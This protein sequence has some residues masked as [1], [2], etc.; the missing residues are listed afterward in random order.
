MYSIGRGDEATGMA[1]KLVHAARAIYGHLSDRGRNRRPEQTKYY[2]AIG[3]LHVE[4]THFNR[5]LVY[6]A[7]FLVVF[8]L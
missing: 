7:T 4:N 2:N 8:D 5:V 1:R 6:K 3:L